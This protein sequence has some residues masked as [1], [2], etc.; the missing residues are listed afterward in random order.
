MVCGC[1]GCA[2][3]AHAT[4]GEVG[5]VEYHTCSRVWGCKGCSCMWSAGMLSGY[6]VKGVQGC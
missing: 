5:L 6:I 3:T 4:F 1:M 2:E